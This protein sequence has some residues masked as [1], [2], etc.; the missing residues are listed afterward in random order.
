MVGTINIPVRITRLDFASQERGHYRFWII[1]AGMVRLSDAN[2]LQVAGTCGVWI[3]RALPF[4]DTKQH[5]CVE[6]SGHET[7]STRKERT[8]SPHKTEEQRQETESFLKF[9]VIL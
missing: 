3:G 1:T 7:L 4:V 2:G 5:L 9:A 8:G 6:V